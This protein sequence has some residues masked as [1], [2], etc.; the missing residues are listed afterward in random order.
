[1]EVSKRLVKK[2][3]KVT[4]L[5]EDYSEELKKRENIENISVFRIKYPKIKFVGLLII[6]LNIIKNRHLIQQADII[7]I[8]DVFIWY[9]PLRFIFAKKK[10]FIT[11]HGWEGKYPIP[12]I[13]IIQ[14]RMAWKLT[15][16]NICVGNYISK[17]YGIKSDIVTFGGVNTERDVLKKVKNSIVY[18]GRLEKGTG[19][20]PFLGWL[21]NNHKYNIE[22]CGDGSLRNE[23]EK[24]GKV[25]GFSDPTLFLKRS[26]YCAPGGYLSALEAMVCK[27]KILVFWHNPLKKDYW[28]TAPFY[29]WIKNNNTEAAYIWARTQTWDKIAEE[30]LT[31]W[32]I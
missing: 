12:K 15:E 8:H 22:F 5:T 29:G 19:L 23:C 20:R 30:Y 28:Q 31:L 4:V 18:V 9:L 10:V 16:G 3:N 27:C 11:F 7:H 2:G 1:M 13:S 17:Y 21:K 32:R 26:E 6:W 24:F 14:K 25:K